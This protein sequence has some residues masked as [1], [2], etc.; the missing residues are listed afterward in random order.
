MSDKQKSAELILKLYELRRD[1]TMRKARNWWISFNP[2]SP[3]DI[4]ATLS[5]EHSGYYRMVSTY[6]DMAAA[7]VLH[8]AV[9]EQMFNDCNGEHMF[10]FAKIEPHLEG[11]RAVMGP[12]V[13]KS[14]EQLIA[15]TEGSK[16][17]LA[18][19]RDLSRKWAAARAEA[20]RAKAQATPTA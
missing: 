4:L 18:Q 10:V 13:L 6:W 19:I 14:L 1:E 11:V 8:G 16:E 7:L 17:R 12:N 2:S 20:E 5:S 3:Q 15:R 9:D